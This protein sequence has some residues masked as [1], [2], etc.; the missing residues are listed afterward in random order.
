M[1]AAARLSGNA[2]TTSRSLLTLL[3]DGLGLSVGLSSSS[4]L[5]ATFSQSRASDE[6]TSSRSAQ[7]LE[8]RCLSGLW[9][10]AITYL[11]ELDYRASS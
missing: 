3:C 7:A 6:S 8:A 5:R 10:Y 4:P 1:L 2:L 9:C 11:A